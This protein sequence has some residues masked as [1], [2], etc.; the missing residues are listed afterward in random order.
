MLRG[1]SLVVT[2][3]ALAVSTIQ[4]G[5]VKEYKEYV[6][7]EER[8]FENMV[9]DLDTFREVWDWYL[10]TEVGEN[11]VVRWKLE[12]MGP[13]SPSD[14]K[15]ADVGY[16]VFEDPKQPS[17]VFAWYIKETKPGWLFGNY[18]GSGYAARCVYYYNDGKLLKADCDDW[19]LVGA[20]YFGSGGFYENY[21]SGWYTV[22]DTSSTAH[23]EEQLETT[24][25][26]EP[27]IADIDPYGGKRSD[28]YASGWKKL[29]S[30]EVEDGADIPDDLFGGYKRLNIYL[31]DDSPDKVFIELGDP[32]FSPYIKAVQITA[33]TIFGV[34]SGEKEDLLLETT[35]APGVEGGFHETTLL[36]YEFDKPEGFLDMPAYR[37][38][39]D[40][41]YDLEDYGTG[42][43][44]AELWIER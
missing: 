8:L 31:H 30:L 4:A 15:P 39:L 9:A 33:I 42:K 3:M 11:N 35:L 18:Y 20:H 6:A 17:G 25:Y 5:I 14:N 34:Y 24:P 1:I 19:L 41:T 29:D 7:R 23:F 12:R 37:L 32:Y 22:E 13:Y 10:Y 36:T 26:E 28:L 43:M 44:Q 16:I 40:M 21:V 2:V 27:D 38:L